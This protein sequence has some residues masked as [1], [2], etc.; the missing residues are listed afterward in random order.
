MA[1]M[2]HSCTATL[3]SGKQCDFFVMDNT[4]RGQPC[5]HPD[6]GFDYM[7]HHWDEEPDH[8]DSRDERDDIEGDDDD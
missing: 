6:H 2:E 3:D 7:S 8:N 5:P 4:R 1:C